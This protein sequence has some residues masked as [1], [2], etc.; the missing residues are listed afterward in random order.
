MRD[1]GGDPPPFGVPVAC[2]ERPD[3]PAGEDEDVLVAPSVPAVRRGDDGRTRRP[4]TRP[5][6]HRPRGRDRP[7]SSV[8]ADGPLPA[9]DCA[10]VEQVDRRRR[11]GAARRRPRRD[12]AARR[13]QPGQ[14]DPV[15]GRLRRPDEPGTG[16]VPPRAGGPDQPAGRGDHD[17][18]DR[19]RGGALARHPP[20]RDR[21]RRQPDVRV[22]APAGVDGHGRPR[23][24]PGRARRQWRAVQLLDRPRTRRQHAGGRDST[25]RRCPGRRG[26]ADGLPRREETIPGTPQPDPPDQP[27]PGPERLL[28]LRALPRPAPGLDH[29]GRV[30]LPG[31]R[32]RTF[33]GGRARVPARVPRHDLREPGHQRPRGR[34]GPVHL[35]DDPLRRA[36]QAEDAGRRQDQE[37]DAHVH[38]RPADRRAALGAV[39]RLGRP[40]E[41]P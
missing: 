41:G 6:H 21:Q 29:A 39:P 1:A 9:D 18:A 40:E 25:Q 7:P 34:A 32:G 5:G 13:L 27:R 26:R 36:G 30:H 20:H 11:R 24:R 38:Q 14:A 37:G 2:P 16:H 22:P 8:P 23:R 35:R 31:L 17:V 4:G 10:R 15:P 12:Q 3:R 33:R 28:G 19:S